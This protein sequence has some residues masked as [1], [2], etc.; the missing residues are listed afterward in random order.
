MTILVTL[1]IV[2]FGILSYRNLPIASI[3]NIQTPEITISASYPGAS[4]ETV[5]SAVASP[6]E[7][8]CL[9]ISGVKSVESYNSF[10]STSVVLDLDYGTNVNDIIPDIQAAIQSAKRNMPAL[11]SDPV[12]YRGN[13]SDMPI[14]D[15]FYY[16]TVL[17]SKDL[18]SMI[19]KNVVQPM[20]T[21]P[22]V[23]QV[24]VNSPNYSINIDVN[25]VK[26]AAYSLTFQDV[27]KAIVQ[28]NVASS[29]G[30][31]YGNYK[32]L[33]VNPQGQISSADKFNKIVIKRID[34]KDIT[35][36][37]IGKTYNGKDDV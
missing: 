6:L 20:Q 22:G 3:P 37:D 13:T 17:N 10:G 32:N 26:M 5:A 18:V 16:S 27:E 25:P 9:G 28:A 14:L 24:T 23:S 34:G 12:Y 33:L 30:K 4:P 15:Y 31:L 2:I 35:V 8:A 36:S 21:L 29:G 11:P 1:A 7:K 19:T